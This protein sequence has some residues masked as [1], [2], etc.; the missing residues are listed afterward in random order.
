MRYRRI[1]IGI[2]F[3]RPSTAAARWVARWFAPDAELI[4]VHAFDTSRPPDFVAGRELSFDIDADREKRRLASRLNRVARTMKHDRVSVRV[5]EGR[6]AR[7]IAEAAADEEAD[8]IV[9]GEHARRNPMRD[10]LSTTAEALLALAPV[11]V[12]LARRPQA[13]PTRAV[14]A[15]IEPSAIASDILRAAYGIGQGSRT[16]VVALYVLHAHWAARVALTSADPKAQ[17]VEEQMV[18]AGRRW[19]LGQL[20]ANDMETARVTPIVRVGEPRSEIVKTVDAEDVDMIVMGSRG[21]GGIAQLLL[22]SVARSVLR[23]APCPVLVLTERS[24]RNQPREVAA[25]PGTE[26]KP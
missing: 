15:P 10:L 14:L 20:R 2:D 18:S 17:Q 3:S 6:A 11:P 23:A 8:L 5:H 7:V 21:G 19:L 22:G 25:L 4:L 13:R 16:R 9:V 26:R 24:V 12:L 1:V